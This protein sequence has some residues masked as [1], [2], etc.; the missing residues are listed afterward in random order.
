MTNHRT[1]WIRRTSLSLAIVA[2]LGDAAQAAPTLEG[3]AVLPATTVSSGPTTG[4]FGGTGFGANSNLLPIQNAQSVQGFSGVLDGPRRGTY[5]VL[6]DNGFGAITNSADALLRMYAVRP[7][8]RTWRGDRVVGTGDV[9]PVSFR[10]GRPLPS[11]DE[12]SFLDLRD[13]S[14]EL[15]FPLQADLANYYGVATNP[16]VDPSIKGGRLLTG[17][18]LDVESVRVDER[19]HFWFGDEFG[20]FLVETDRTG[21]VLGAEIPLPNILPSGSTATGLFV[22]SPQNP[23]LVGSPNLGSSRGFEGMAIDRSGR[24]LYTL[25]EGTVAGDPVKSLRIDEFDVKRRKFTGRNFLYA[26][27][28]QGTNIG[29]MTAIDDHRFLVL[30]RNG[31]TATTPGAP[32]KR[33]FVI[34]VDTVDANGFV[35]KTDLVD[36]MNV[37][38]PHDLNGDGSTTFTFPYV[39]IESVLILDP[40]TLLVINDNNFPGGGGRDAAPDQTEFLR[41]RLDAPILEDCDEE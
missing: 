37:A 32:Y 22:Q 18:D 24:K 38:D 5:Y 36:L 40:R 17:A 41:I 11:F 8:F 2:S 13:P 28:A 15:Q 33:I 34:D 26:L 21:R 16:P 4:Q 6:T 31:N 10:D 35:Q 25:L 7:A 27:D 14:H 20:P 19:G 9:R 3:W 30:E 1:Q 23:H 39:T 29:D 12:R